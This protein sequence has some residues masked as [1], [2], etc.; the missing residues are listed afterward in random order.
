MTASRTSRLDVSMQ[1]VDRDQEGLKGREKQ[2]SK[3]GACSHGAYWQRQ[4][5]ARG[6]SSTRV[7]TLDPCPR[8]YV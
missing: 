8:A 2:D 6:E 5:Y 7:P 3:V 4:Y 1:L